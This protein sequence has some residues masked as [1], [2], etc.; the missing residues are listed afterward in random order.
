M[1][2]EL[3][4]QLNLQKVRENIKKTLSDFAAKWDETGGK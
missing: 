1:N 4:H 3:W 2:F